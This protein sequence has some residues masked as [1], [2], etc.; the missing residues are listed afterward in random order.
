MTTRR[1]LPWLA[2]ALCLLCAV[3]APAQDQQLTD[4]QLINDIIHYELIER[5]RLAA[6][7]GRELM[8]RAYAPREFVD[9]VTETGDEARF[10]D[11]L[12]G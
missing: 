10:L 4:E 1:T 2:A 5:P 11:A 7:A 3:V 6:A 9:I 8:S 12:R